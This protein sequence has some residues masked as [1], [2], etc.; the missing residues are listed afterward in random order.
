MQHPKF[1]ERW[2]ENYHPRSHWRETSIQRNFSESPAEVGR[3]I[4]ELEAERRQD[5][6]TYW[7]T[8]LEIVA[9]VAVVGGLCVAT[10]HLLT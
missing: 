4:E 6:P 7:R 8:Y 9:S 5:L 2:R 1:V 3:R 10:W